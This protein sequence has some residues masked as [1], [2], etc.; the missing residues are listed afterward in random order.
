MKIGVTYVLEGS[1][2]LETWSEISRQEALG[3]VLQLKDMPSGGLPYRFYR[4]RTAE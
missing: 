2:N 4:A 1:R 3:P